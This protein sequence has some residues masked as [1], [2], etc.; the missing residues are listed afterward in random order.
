MKRAIFPGTFDPITMGHFGVI[1]KGLELFDEI[2]VAIGTNSKKNHLF[3]LTQRLEWIQAAFKAEP[4][5]K[6]VAY[7]GLTVAFCK[8]HE[9]QF[10]LRGLRTSTDFE[11]EQSIA[12]ANKV[13]APDI[14][15][16]F[17][18]ANPGHTSI[19]ST[20]VREVIV[21]GGDASSF[22]PPGVVL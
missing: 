4:R 14:E 10:I 21:A 3:S 17:V 19:S 15:T 2:I 11:Y 16:V 5:V 6:V 20:I 9:A 13:L 7:D 8:E 1:Q 22:V 12:H 18:L